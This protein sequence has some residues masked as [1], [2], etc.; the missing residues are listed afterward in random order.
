MTSGDCWSP[1]GPFKNY[2]TLQGA[3]GSLTVWEREEGS[4]IALCRTR[5]IYMAPVIML[6]TAMLL[7]MNGLL[8]YLWTDVGQLCYGRQFQSSA[9]LTISRHRRPIVCSGNLTVREMT[10]WLWTRMKFTFTL[11]FT[12]YA[13]WRGLKPLWHNFLR[14]G[15]TCDKL[16]QRLN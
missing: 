15:E 1:L 10:C 12:R 13:H 9:N 11:F 8:V 6:Y 16:W 4:T 3:E 2:V 5:A 14:G 7:W